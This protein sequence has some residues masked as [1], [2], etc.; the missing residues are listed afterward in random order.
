MGFPGGSVVKNPPTYAGDTGSIP[1]LRRSP[2][3]VMA[4]HEQRC[5]LGYSP[6]DHKRVG[7]D[8]VTKQ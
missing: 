7:H 6:W 5:L 8:V 4:T 3:N 2:E 1:E